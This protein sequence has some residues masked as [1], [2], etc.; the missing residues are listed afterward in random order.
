MTEVLKSGHFLPTSPG[1]LSASTIQF[2]SLM[3]ECFLSIRKRHG[4]FEVDGTEQAFIGHRVGKEGVFV[5]WEWTGSQLVVENDRY[6]LCPVYYTSG[7]NE[8][9]IGTS[10]QQLID[11]GASTELDYDALAVFL[12]CGIFLGNDTPFKSIRVLPPG[13]TFRWTGSD[14]HPIENIVLG[15]EARGLGFDEACSRYGELFSESIKKR[16]D[17]AGEVAV[18]LSGGMDSRHIL[19]ELCH[20]GRKPTLCVTSRVYPGKSSEDTDLAEQITRLAGVPCVQL[21][22]DGDWVQQEVQKL[23]AVN[24]CTMQHN[25]GMGL[26]RYLEGKVVALFDG[27]AGDVLSDCR[28][29]VTPARHEAF[30]SGHFAEFAEDLLSDESGGLGF[31]RPELARQFSRER[32]VRRISSECAQF[33]EAP[34]PVAA[35]WFWNRTR[36]SIGLLPQSIWNRSVQVMTPYLDHALFDFLISLPV[37]IVGDHTFHAETIRRRYPR[38]SHI[39][40]FSSACRQP[41]PG[42]RTYRKRAFDLL[43]HGLRSIPSAYVPSGY[44]IS[45]LLRALID[46]KYSASVLWLGPTLLYGLEL[47]RCSSRNNVRRE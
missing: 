28:G 34:N 33:A 31:L 44:L 37:G 36:R 42:S 29:I 30:R 41:E 35:F 12:R 32:A 19:L 8:F 2:G 6:G 5:Q 21:D 18:P 24:F 9:C 16:S 15:E 14:E 17:L 27:L 13:V 26:G 10:I 40:F 25:W 11:H 23:R 39:P 20:L 7:R 1:S 22:Q 46:S 3:S 38:F 4:R 45:C 43:L 47:E